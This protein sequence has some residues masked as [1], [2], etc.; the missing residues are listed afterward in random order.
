MHRFMDGYKT[1]PAGD[2]AF[3]SFD[4]I[5]NLPSTPL[6]DMGGNDFG[7]A[8]SSSWDDGASSADSDWN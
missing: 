2:Q 6:D 7:I 1:V 8:D 5:P 3:S 4:S